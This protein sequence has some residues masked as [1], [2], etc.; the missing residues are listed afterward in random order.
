MLLTTGLHKLDL[1]IVVNPKSLQRVNK[2]L[3]QTLNR[4]VIVSDNLRT[5]VPL[6][7]RDS[8]RIQPTRLYSL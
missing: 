3:K 8:P 7:Y 1:R 5:S 2:R 6:R 4:R